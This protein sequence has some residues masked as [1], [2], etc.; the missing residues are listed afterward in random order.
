MLRTGAEYREDEEYL[1]RTLFVLRSRFLERIATQAPDVL[2]GLRKSVLPLYQEAATKE[3]GPRPHLSPPGVALRGYWKQIDA[4][5]YPLTHKLV[6]ALEAW[7]DGHELRDDWLLRIALHTVA[8]W[9]AAS[10]AGHEPPVGFESPPFGAH[11]FRTIPFTFRYPAWNPTHDPWPA[12]NEALRKA[13][14]RAIHAYRDRSEAEPRKRGLR[15]APEKREIDRHLDWLVK[16]QVE[17]KS[18]NK[19]AKDPGA[20]DVRTVQRAV[21]DTARLVGLTLRTKR[22][23]P[24]RK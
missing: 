1:D 20:P 2:E 9:L 18:Y 21:T 19:I 15:P 7:A 10:W 17:G 13:L 8:S 22:K 3:R 16:F 12:Y 24:R 11:W 5:K 6:T 4:A 23:R 14:D